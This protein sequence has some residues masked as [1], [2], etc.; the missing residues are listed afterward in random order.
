M[1]KHILQDRISFYLD[2]DG[3]NHW[4]YVGMIDGTEGTEYF[5]SKPSDLDA[6]LETGTCRVCGKTP[7]RY[8]FI[9]QNT[10]LNPE[11]GW[12]YASVGSECIQFLNQTDLLRIK[13]DQRKLKEKKDRENAKVF[14]SYIRNH[15]LPEHPEV[16]KMEWKYFNYKKNLGSS[17]QFMAEKCKNG[18]PI[19]EKTFGKELKKTL[20]V[21][22]FQLPTVKEMKEEITIPS[23]EEFKA[24]DDALRRAESAYEA[25][26]EQRSEIL[27]DRSLDDGNMTDVE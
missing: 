27:H 26:Y 20:K 23:Y 14:S 9:L 7:I 21:L 12:K 24:D 15:F 17:L 19:H 25:F 10:V 13:A 22:G 1:T 6:E 5:D 11:K 8:N 16:W 18:I 4:K 2:A 3:N